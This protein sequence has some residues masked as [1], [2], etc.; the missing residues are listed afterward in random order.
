MPLYYIDGV[1]DIDGGGGGEVVVKEEGYP[2]IWS[3]DS[4]VGYANYCYVMPFNVDKNVVLFTRQGNYGSTWTGMT[5]LGKTG[6]G[7][8]NAFSDGSISGGHNF[9]VSTRIAEDDSFVVQHY[10]NTFKYKAITNHTVS[11]TYLSLST[12][13]FFSVT[14]SKPAILNS[15]T[16]AIFDSTN[17]KV[18][19]IKLTEGSLVKE[20]EITVSGV[21]GI[22]S[23]VGKLVLL[24]N[25]TE[26]GIRILDIDTEEVLYED[27]R[28]DGTNNPMSFAQ[29]KDNYLFVPCANNTTP[30]VTTP[31]II[32]EYS[33]GQ[34]YKKDM[35]VNGYTETAYSAG[36][37]F[38]VTKNG[39]KYF[40][41]CN[42]GYTVDSLQVLACDFADNSINASFYSGDSSGYFII[43]P[44][45]VDGKEMLFRM[46]TVG[47]AP[48]YFRLYYGNYSATK[49]PVAIEY[50]GNNYI[51]LSSA[52]E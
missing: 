38:L 51:Y 7:T 11:G 41:L 3:N 16:F 28:N 42:L 48:T 8:Q 13:D 30:Y 14:S 18:A 25:S 24:Y 10:N 21:A 39:D 2:V 33:N 50:S 9:F 40:A 34:F 6:T 45:T 5:T 29:E 32:Y 1:R 23:F 36:S 12:S 19:I 31:L 49:Q 37:T 20:K 44:T 26:A 46:K 35:T 17:Q 22:S 52:Q 47:S 43:A 27:I 15:T 4:V